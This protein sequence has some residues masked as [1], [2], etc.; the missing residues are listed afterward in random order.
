MPRNRV[1]INTNYVISDPRPLNPIKKLPLKPWPK[2]PYTPLLIKKPYSIGVGQLP[3]HINSSS[4]Y[5]IFSLYFN[6]SYLQILVDYINK[7]IKLNILK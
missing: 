6:E 1:L 7:Y 2:L 3:S 5:N 4:L